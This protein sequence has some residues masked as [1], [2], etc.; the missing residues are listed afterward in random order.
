MLK[1]NRGVVG[2]SYFSASN[3]I[4]STVT[5]TFLPISH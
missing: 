1:I 4:H 5:Q 3:L 2:V